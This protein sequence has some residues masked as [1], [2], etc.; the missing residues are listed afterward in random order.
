MVVPAWCAGAVA[1]SDASVVAQ[2][3]ALRFQPH[4]LFDSAE[5]WRPVDVDAFLSE[6]G[7]RVCSRPSAPCAA[8]TSV[9]RLT[10]SARYIDLRGTRRDGGDALAPDLATCAKSRPDLLDCDADGR[11]VIYAHVRHRGRRIAID[12]WW[13]LRYNR[14][15]LRHEGDWEGVTVIVDAAGTRVEDVHFAAHSSVWR[16]PRGVPTINARSHVRVYVADGSH[17]AYPRPCRRALCGRLLEGDFDGRSPWVNNDPAVCA[18]RCVR[19]LPRSQGAP[20]SWEAWNGLWG[21]PSSGLLAHLVKPPRTPA[22]Q[23]RYLRPF[24]ARTSRQRRF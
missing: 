3:L 20:A 13:F 19:L 5:R 12:Y 15:P 14:A 1:P 18:Q 11:S 8:S 6:P 10:P 2:D 9:A 21:V 17:A 24:D 22:F 4:L 23:R 16:Y 7:H